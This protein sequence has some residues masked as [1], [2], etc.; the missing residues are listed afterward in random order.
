MKE[1]NQPLVSVITVCLNSRKYLEEAIKSLSEQ[2]YLNIEYIVLDGGSTDGSIDILNKYKNKINKIVVEKDNGIFDAMNKGIKLAEGNIIY[3]LNSDDRF[4]NNQVVEKAVTA[5]SRYKEED[6]IYG[7]IIAFNPV[8]GYAYI[9]R[10]PKKISKWLFIRKTIGHPATFFR[11]SCFKKAGYF[12]ERYKIAADY[13]W[14]LRALFVKKLKSK[15][16]KDNISIF[17]LGGISNNRK[18]SEVYI[19]ERKII[20][21]KYFNSFE[22]ACTDGLEKLKRINRC[23]KMRT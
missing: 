20:Q 16:I 10:Y 22:L 21:K 5:F 15:H 8:T 19:S 4:Y 11:S 17:S 7:N 6:F 23:L 1:E 12:D 3:F 18:Y 14:Y 9:E 13:E 2:T